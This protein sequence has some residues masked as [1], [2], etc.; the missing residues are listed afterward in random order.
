MVLYEQDDCSKLDGLI[1][2]ASHDHRTFFLRAGHSMSG[3]NSTSRS[4][5][6]DILQVRELS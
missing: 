6:Q 5:S 3:Y 4:G 1:L 2:Q